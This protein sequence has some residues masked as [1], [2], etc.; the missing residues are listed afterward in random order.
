MP[1]LEGTRAR[2]KKRDRYQAMADRALADLDAWLARIGRGA[3]EV[4]AAGE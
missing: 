3:S 1:P 4:R 2:L